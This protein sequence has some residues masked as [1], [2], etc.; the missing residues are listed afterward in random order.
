MPALGRIL[1]L[2]VATTLFA[3]CTG[4]ALRRP[5]SSYLLSKIESQ[6]FLLSPD[7]ANSQSDHETL[8][9][10]LPQG[11]ENT[12]GAAAAKC[13][14]KGTWFSLHQ[15][16]GSERSW[17]VD[18]PSA[19]AWEANAG[20]I[21]MKDEWKSFERALYGLQQGRC[22]SSLDEYLSV[23]QRIAASLSAPVEDTLFYRYSYGPGGYVDLAPK[24]QLR[25]ERDFFTAHRSDHPNPADYQGTTITYYDV[26]GT[27][28]TGTSLK[29]L[30]VEKK[31]IR[32]IAPGSKSSDVALATQFAAAPRLRLF[33]QDL[34]VSGDAK[35]PAILIG[36]SLNQDLS[37]VTQ[38]IETD[39]NISCKALLRRQVT[40]ALFDGVVTVSPMLQ[41]FINGTR[42]YVPIGSKL[43]SIL[44]Q[45]TTLQRTAM[46]QTLHIERSFQG[47]PVRVQFPPDLE[48]ISQLPLSG[49][50]RISWSRL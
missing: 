10:P 24:M 5:Q 18:T 26:L 20:A 42:T 36:A 15:S 37:E 39:P 29:F 1:F 27:A 44:P 35:T 23:R 4:C 19:S 41:V 49:G 45:L 33:L 28:E 32:S 48:G 40:C 6:Y 2:A 17:I 25:I 16:S 11:S 43:L 38:A 46:I 8:R 22:F 21:D 47:R 9:I 50:D 34:V 7:A 14:I 31:A 30:R 12:Q 3:G 13:S